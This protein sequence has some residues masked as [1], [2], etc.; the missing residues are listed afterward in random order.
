MINLLSHFLELMLNAGNDAV[1]KKKRLY[2]IRFDGTFL[3][4]RKCN[5]LINIIA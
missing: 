1:I 4:R 3:L 2:N 5:F